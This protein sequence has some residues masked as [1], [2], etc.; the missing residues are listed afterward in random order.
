MLAGM[1]AARAELARDGRNVRGERT[2]AAVV[3][4]MLGLLDEGDVR[5]TTQR[6]AERAGVS[7]RTIFQ[8]FRDREALFEAVARRQY[9]RVVPTLSPISPDLPL[10]ERIDVFADQRARLY[11]MVSGVRRGAVLLE[12]ESDVVHEQLQAVRRAKAKEVERVF[13]AE[14]GAL[15]A[16]EREARRAA[17]GAACAWTA[18][19]GLRFHQG[20]NAADAREAMRSALAALLG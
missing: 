18:W 3:E 15:P 19:E 6:I 5:P 1:E 4:A 16:R 14:L 11:E 20:L 17:I 9:D 13:A 2:R 8:H 10:A 12:H 7:E